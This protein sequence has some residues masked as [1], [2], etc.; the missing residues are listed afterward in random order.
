[1]VKHPGKHPDYYLE[2]M[3]L[4]SQISKWKSKG[5]RAKSKG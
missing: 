5:R 1:M 4:L 3:E 2:A